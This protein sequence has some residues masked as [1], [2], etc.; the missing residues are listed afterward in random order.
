MTDENDRRMCFELGPIRPPSEAGS[1]LLRLTRNCPWNQ[2]AFCHSYKGEKFSRRSVEEVRADIDAI[3]HIAGRIREESE[4]RGKPVIDREV[5]S[6]VI[7]DDGIDEQYVRQTAFWLY[8]GMESLFLQDADSLVLKAD[9]VAEILIYIREQFPAIRRI[10]TYARAKTISRRSM[11]DLLKLRRAGLDRLH[12]GLE[13]GSDTVLKLIRKGVTAEEHINAGKKAMDAGFELSEYYM[14]GAGGKEHL[15]ENGHESAR[16]L[17]EINPTFIRLRSVVPLPDTPLFQLIND[18]LWAV[19]TEEDRVREI[20]IFLKSLGDITSTLKSDH[21]MNL[22]EDIEGR[23]PEDRERMIQTI[24]SFMNM[25][26]EHR[27]LFIIGRR[28]GRFRYLSDYRPSPELE[29]M[30][31]KIKVSDASLDDVILEV[32]WNYI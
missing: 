15:E 21:V 12:I 13:S 28:L 8:H 29:Q 22:I 9:D 32:L 20:G 25:P 27:E 3:A 2:C 26:L 31:M 23:F 19:P 18:G 1:I 10:T 4:K 14:P 5:L 17:T 30:R 16:V 24:D 6:P 7:I 11:E